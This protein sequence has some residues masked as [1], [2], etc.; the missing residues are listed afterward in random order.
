MAQEQPVR[1][2]SMSMPE[3]PDVLLDRSATATVHSK[4][5]MVSF[6][7]QGNQNL[8]LRGFGLLAVAEQER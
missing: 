7:S 1:M 4:C 3:L 8:L 6:F 5:L 2:Q